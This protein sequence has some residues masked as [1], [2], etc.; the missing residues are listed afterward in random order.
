MWEPA[1][2]SPVDDA[3]RLAA[4]R[5]TLTRRR[6]DHDA[7][8]LSEAQ[9]PEAR[10]DYFHAWAKILEQQSGSALLQGKAE[11]DAAQVVE[12]QAA[13]DRQPPLFHT[14]RRCHVVRVAQMRG[15]R[16]LLVAE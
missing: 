4:R 15:E 9:S 5:L 7:R 2:E 10:L 11:G 14:I 6:G 1:D 3:L 13:I 16:V 8:L 12:E